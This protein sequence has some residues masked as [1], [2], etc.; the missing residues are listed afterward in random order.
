MD[1]D[2]LLHEAGERWRERQGPTVLSPNLGSSGKEAPT[3]K[4]AQ[5]LA[6]LGAAAVAAGI[7]LVIVFLQDAASGPQTA[8]PRIG[9]LSCCKFLA[10]A[11]GLDIST[12]F[13]HRDDV[14]HSCRYMCCLSTESFPRH[15]RVGRWRWP[16]SNPS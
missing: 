4:S 1:I 6:P 13:E 10:E 14:T 7:V 15:G 11:N 12:A 5:R 9:K 2:H 3:P 16:H 8:P